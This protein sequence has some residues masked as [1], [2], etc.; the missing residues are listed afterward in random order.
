[1]RLEA[2]GK[3]Y[4]LRQTIHC[5]HNEIKI[6]AIRDLEDIKLYNEDPKKALRGADF[7]RTKKK[8]TIAEKQSKPLEQASSHLAEQLEQQR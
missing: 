3:K 6:K 4:S 7:Q 1:M 5:G 8:A 2:T